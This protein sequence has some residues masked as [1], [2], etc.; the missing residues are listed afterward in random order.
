MD[1]APPLRPPSVAEL[2]QRIQAER[3]GEPF[4]LYRDGDGHQRILMLDPEAAPVT[5]GRQSDNAVPLAW[6]SEVSRVHA[7]LVR[8]GSS[9]TLADD[10]LSR[11][12]SYVNDERVA[13]R[14]RLDHGDVVLVG[15]TVL[16]FRCPSAAESEATVAT[17][18]AAAARQL[19]A[20]QR[21]VLIALCRPFRDSS[22]A[23]PATNQ[24]IAEELYLSV[25]AVKSHLRKLFVVFEVSEMPQN[26]KRSHLAWQA[27][28]SGVISVR[29]L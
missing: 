23:T 2:E 5:V 14:R 12:G 15:R 16:H 17:P 18:D 25:D 8:V 4:L 11:N 1:A 10:G 26:A 7:E 28:A 19:S 27:L 3:R 24:Q 9:W 29:E 13:G 6:D 22:F 21:R 20:G